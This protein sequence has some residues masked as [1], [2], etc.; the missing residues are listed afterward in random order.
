MTHGN[1]RMGDS[2]DRQKLK[3][4]VRKR[5]PRSKLPQSLA[6]C[7]GKDVKSERRRARER[8]R[9]A[10]LMLGLLPSRLAGMHVHHENH[11]P[12]D[13]RLSNLVPMTASAHHALHRRRRAQKRK[14]QSRSK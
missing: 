1:G 9:N 6:G 12:L 13:N 3:R 8:A 10:V 14:R 2:C 4:W 7:R 5:A 11:D